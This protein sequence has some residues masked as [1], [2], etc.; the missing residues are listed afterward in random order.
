MASDID[1][2]EH[3]LFENPE[4]RVLFPDITAL[5]QEIYDEDFEVTN[6]HYDQT[7]QKCEY[8]LELDDSQHFDENKRWTGKKKHALQPKTCILKNEIVGSKPKSSKTKDFPM[9]HNK[10]K[11]VAMPKVG[12][13]FET[14]KNKISVRRPPKTSTER[15]R[16]SRERKKALKIAAGQIAPRKLKTKPKTPAER[17]RDYRAR[18]RARK[19]AVNESNDTKLIT[20]KIEVDQEQEDYQPSISISPMRKVKTSTERCRA[21]RARKKSLMNPT[22]NIEDFQT[23]HVIND[24]Y[25]NDDDNHNNIDDENHNINSRNN[26]RRIQDDDLRQSCREKSET[27]VPSFSKSN[28]DHFHPSITSLWIEVPAYN[29][30]EEGS[31]LR[32]ITS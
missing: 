3:N 24:N 23:S 32:I 9:K 22:E 10:T 26:T 20:I 28:S 5:K 25:N 6:I 15:S 19:N 7:T 27:A 29:E 8:Q 4:L 31:S 11:Q 16:E 30:T 21:F 17:S 1:I 12:R 18:K 13:E 2:E 14:L